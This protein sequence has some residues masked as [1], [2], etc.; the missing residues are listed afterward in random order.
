MVCTTRTAG[1]RLG[2]LSPGMPCRKSVEITADQRGTM[3]AKRGG[4]PSNARLCR[5]TRSKKVGFKSPRPPRI[6][7]FSGLFLCGVE[8]RLEVF[9]RLFPVAVYTAGAK[10]AYFAQAAWFGLV[11]ALLPSPQCRPDCTD[12]L[13]LQLLRSVDNK[14]ALYSPVIRKYEYR[15]RRSPQQKIKA[16]MSGRQTFPQ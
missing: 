2:A 3:R 9:R 5:T 14:P 11:T 10:A 12:L 1:L 4:R 13:R 8:R 6:L 7:R 16:L 15:C